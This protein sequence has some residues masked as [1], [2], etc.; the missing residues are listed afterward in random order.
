MHTNAKRRRE[1]ASAHLLKDASSRERREEGQVKRN[2]TYARMYGCC[3]AAVSLAD[4]VVRQKNCQVHEN[5]NF[6]ESVLSKCCT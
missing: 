5:E 4:I 2:H 3:M 6:M 1:L